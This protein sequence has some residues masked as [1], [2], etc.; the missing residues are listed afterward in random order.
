MTS[1]NLNNQLVESAGHS[2][3]LAWLV[4][5]ILPELASGQLRIALHTGETIERTGA[6][7]GHVAEIAIHRRRGLRR[8]LL[9]GE[10]GFVEGFLEG[11]WSTP[12]LHAL[13]GFFI[14]NEAAFERRGRN[15]RLTELRHRLMHRFRANSPRGS[16]R[17]IAAHYDLGNDFYAS[18][19]D[20]GMNYSS[21]LYR[22]S[23]TLEEAQD[24]KL[25]R[26]IALLD[27]GAG[28][29]VLEIGCGWG[30]LAE[31]LVR[32]G[33]PV[34]A[35]T[36]SAEQLRY[37]GQ[38]LSAAGLADRADL[39]LQDY[40]DVDG[41]YDR[42]VSIEMLEAVGERY[43]P[44]YFGKLRESLAPGGLAVLQVIT[45]EE[46]RFAAYR[47]RPDFI[48][49]YI[50]PGGM[51]PTMSRIEAEAA[52]AGLTLCHRES[53]GESYARTL[54][55]WRERF[56]SSWHAIEPLGFDQRFRKMWEYYLA[57]CEAGFRHKALDVSLFKFST[58]AS[59]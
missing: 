4:G 50:F 38:R 58:A 17:N 52:R 55:E 12:D 47:S 27:P 51:L 54:R 16:R 46:A 24:A 56:V 10:Q 37:A 39:R 34:T 5:K 3:W 13:L 15:T 42:I 1:L 8:M 40:R 30:A 23:E 25:E 43:W 9:D 2:G 32:R 7:A 53:F 33:S 26:V 22:G 59:V 41:C 36:L 45:I 19:L 31:R 35:V 20:A 18:W 48:Q 29:R 44:V 14:E 6:T 57:Y 28:D 11:D 21:G 49:S